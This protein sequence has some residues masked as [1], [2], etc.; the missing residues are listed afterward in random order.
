MKVAERVVGCVF[1][2]VMLPTLILV[3]VLIH[4]AA[5]RPVLVTDEFPNDRGTVTRRLRFRTTGRGTD[6]F[7]AM[8]RL[9][10]RYSIDEWPSLWSVVRGDIALNDLLSSRAERA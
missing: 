9:L 1:L 8:G 7:R 10:R 2:I 3:A 4:T 5:G 6:F